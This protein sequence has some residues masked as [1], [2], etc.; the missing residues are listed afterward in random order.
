MCYDL[1]MNR[2]NVE[3]L[4]PKLLERSGRVFGI[5]GG[6][7]FPARSADEMGVLNAKVSA[8]LDRALGRGKAAPTSAGAPIGVSAQ[9]AVSAALG[10]AAS[11]AAAV[12]SPAAPVTAPPKAGTTDEELLAAA[13][14]RFG[15]SAAEMRVCRATGKD[16]EELARARDDFATKDSLATSRA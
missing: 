9:A 3:A 12:A 7:P 14:R 2:P 11:H 5:V 15:L 16:P 10:V 1:P 13:G 6:I 4:R 8:G